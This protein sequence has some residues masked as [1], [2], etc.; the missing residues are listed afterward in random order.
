MLNQ[1][2]SAVSQK[3]IVY[4]NVYS[5]KCTMYFF[6]EQDPNYRIQ[7]SRDPL[8]FQVVWQKIGRQLIKYL[9][10]VSSNIRDF[11]TL[12][13]AKYL[14]GD[15]NPRGFNEFFLK[16]EQVCAYARGIYLSDINDRF[17][18]IEFI[19]KN[20]NNSSYSISL[21]PKDTILSN[22]RVYGILGKYN[23]PYSEMSID[24][25]PEFPEIINDALN[26]TEKNDLTKISD[27]LISNKQLILTKE[28]LV[29]FANILKTLSVAE[30]SLYRDYILKVKSDESHIQNQLYNCMINKDN[31]IKDDNLEFYSFTNGIM[32]HSKNSRLS[33]IIEEI[34][35]TDKILTTHLAV[36]RTLQSKSN[37]TYKEIKSHA[38]FSNIPASVGY[39]F[40]PDETEI[41][42]LNSILDKD[43]KTIDKVKYLVERNRRVCKARKNSPWIQ[44]EK[45]IFKVYYSDGAQ[46]YDQIDRD[47]NNE[48]DYFLGSYYRLF[49]QIENQT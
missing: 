18:G 41:N 30:Q 17:N 48:F 2:D 46:S 43:F 9:S 33:E 24:Q 38:L 15:H 14:Y 8:G 23:R 7:G 36:F 1:I 6:T 4:N 37:W 44:H 16:F 42:E 34:Q 31:L 47:H 3:S 20:K 40:P 45:N 39:S 21:N 32:H 11:Q 13:Y 26:K 19:N 28:Q 5:I 29:P 22:Q 10:T 49:N 12:S 27:K 35:N 25:D